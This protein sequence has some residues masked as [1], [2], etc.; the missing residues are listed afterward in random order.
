M[1][2]PRVD[3]PHKKPLLWMA[4]ISAVVWQRPA[5]ALKHQFGV[6]I[7]AAGLD[8][9]TSLRRRRGSAPC[10]PGRSGLL[11]MGT[12]DQL[13]LDLGQTQPHRV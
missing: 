7:A 8:G 13:G 5:H 9:W 10:D 3:G 6:T 12:S 1:E 4:R 2:E 11:N